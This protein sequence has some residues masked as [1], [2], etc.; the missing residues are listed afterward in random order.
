MK[1]SNS[2]ILLT[3][4]IQV[5]DRI[6]RQY[7][8]RYWGDLKSIKDGSKR[9]QAIFSDGNAYDYNKDW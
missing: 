9:Y 7:N 1:F 8:I 2:Q 5:F 6:W 4:K 3:E